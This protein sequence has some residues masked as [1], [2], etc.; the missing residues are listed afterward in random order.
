MTTANQ[1][2]KQTSAAGRRAAEIAESVGADV[3]DFASDVSRRAGEH[4]TRAQDMA[5]KL[6]TKPMLPCGAIQ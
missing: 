4:L 6:S 3:S 1:A 5:W 2:Y